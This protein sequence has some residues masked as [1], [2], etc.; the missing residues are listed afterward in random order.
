MKVSNSAEQDSLGLA[1]S[2]A[3]GYADSVVPPLNIRGH[4]SVNPGNR[5]LD[6]D[7]RATVLGV[8][9]TG[10]NPLNATAVDSHNVTLIFVTEV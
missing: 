9:P 5:F 3:V 8:V 2:F 6:G 7:I 10:D 4:D 1:L